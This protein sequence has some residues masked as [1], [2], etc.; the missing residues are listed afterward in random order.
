MQSIVGTL[1]LLITGMVTYHGF[2]NPKYMEDHLFHVD[3]ILI[4][5]EYK[6]ILSSGFLHANWIHF[7]FNMLALISFSLSLEIVF[8]VWQYALIYFASLIGGSL[9]SLYIHR[10]HG[11][12][13][14][15]GA[16]GAI[17]GVI[18]ASIVLFPNSDISFILL[19]FSIKNWV[20][21]VLFI[22]ISIFGIKSNAGVIGHDAH[23]G[24]AIVGVLTALALKPFLFAA[25]WW[26]ALLILI[27]SI[28]F[29]I[30]IIRNPA[31]LMI[32]NY[33]GE[34]V[35]K[36]RQKPTFTKP[37]KEKSLNEI[38]DKIKTHGIDSLTD[39]ERQTL[40]NLKN[41]L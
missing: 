39:A 16:S 1:I 31:V 11:D 25:N 29:L 3:R 26:I 6:R 24:G 19:P 35:K 40:D 37:N 21:G 33:W 23:F 41:D 4:A 10:N 32:D 5:K 8:G 20:F 30:L 9:L 28:V 13:R 14:A 27:P 34:T 12:Y 22:A 38:L 15:L 17:S 7:G 18:M 36:V 2:R